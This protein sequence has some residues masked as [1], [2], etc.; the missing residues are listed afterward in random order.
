M[1]VARV[2]IGIRSGRGPIYQRLPGPLS[3]REPRPAVTG[4]QRLATPRRA[5]LSA[6]FD[7]RPV[8]DERTGK[9]V[10][11]R[12]RADIRTYRVHADV[13]REGAV[14]VVIAKDV[15]VKLLT[16]EHPRA[17]FAIGDRAGALEVHDEI[18]KVAGRVHA[19]RQKVKMVRHRAKRVDREIVVLG[20]FAEGAY[21]ELRAVT[22]S[23]QRLA[24]G[25]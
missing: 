23:E 18:E 7:A 24:I 20:A 10:V 19:D 17:M 15:I 9:F 11:G 21:D 13:I 12:L 14:F 1:D 6:V 22:L 5:P 8:R 2:D 4:S 25:A 3:L 16:P